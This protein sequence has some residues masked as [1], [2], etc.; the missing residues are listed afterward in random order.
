MR[1]GL[2]LKMDKFHQVSTDLFIALDSCRK[3]VS[4]LHLAQFFGRLSSN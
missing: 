2:G 4:V 1:S 3:L